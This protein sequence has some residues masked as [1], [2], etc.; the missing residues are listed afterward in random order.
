MGA[1]FLV[2]NDASRCVATGCSHS[3]LAVNDDLTEPFALQGLLHMHIPGSKAN[4]QPGLD[5]PPSAG[6]SPSAVH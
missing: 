5:G 3:V 1:R 4:G 2:P 6:R